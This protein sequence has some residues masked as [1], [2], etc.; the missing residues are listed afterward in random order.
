M[1]SSKNFFLT[2]KGTLRQVLSDF[3][4]WTGESQFQSFI[5]GVISTQLCDL[6][7]P[8]APPLLS[9]STLPPLPCVK[10]CTVF[11]IYVYSVYWGEVWG[12]VGDHIL[13]EFYTLYLT[14]FEADKIA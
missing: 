11:T 8:L 4:V 12:S 1:S 6:Y 9:G 5:H 14:R 3:T 13:Q 10:K 2:C 7:S